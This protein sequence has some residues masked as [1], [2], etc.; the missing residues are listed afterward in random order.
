MMLL[1]QRLFV[2]VFLILLSNP[3]LGGIKKPLRVVYPAPGNSS[4]GQYIEKLLKMALDKSGYAYTLHTKV[5]GVI[6]EQR[7]HAYLKVKSYNVHW[8]MT[9]EVHEAELIPVRVP[10]YK[11]LI[12]WRIFHIRNTDQA[13]FARISNI[14]ELKRLGAGLGHNWPDTTILKN[15]GFNVIP[16]FF[17]DG[18]YEFLKLGRCDYFPRSIIEIWE[19][20]EIAKESNIIIESTLALHYPAAYYFFVSPDETALAQAISE[21]LNKVIDAGEFE[22]HFHRHFLSTI[23][24]ANVKDRRVF[25]VDNPLFSNST[26]LQNEKLWFKPEQY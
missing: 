17:S 25:E 24:R 9:S 4:N 14:N 22:Q 2:L 7:S 10:L 20:H 21:G 13:F 5:T 12:G 18:R 26:V 6:S 16:M 19:E 23:S 11:G 3:S 8:M 1:F 15:A